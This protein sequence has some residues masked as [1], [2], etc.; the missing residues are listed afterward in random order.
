VA[1]VEAAA[2]KN[3]KVNKKKMVLGSVEHFVS[4]S[5]GTAHPGLDRPGIFSPCSA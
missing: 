1:R 4:S 2:E 5:V 3:K